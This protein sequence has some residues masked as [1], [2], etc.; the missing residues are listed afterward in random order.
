M[1]AR[2]AV[3]SMILKKGIR[4]MGFNPEQHSSPFPRIGSARNAGQVKTLLKQC[5]Q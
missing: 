3:I 1:F 5:S 4:I 2:F